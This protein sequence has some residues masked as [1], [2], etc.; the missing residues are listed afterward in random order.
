MGGVDA[1]PIP[2]HGR[3][4]SVTMTL[5]PLGAVFLQPIPEPAPEPA[6]GVGERAQ[7]LRR[8]PTP[9]AEAG[10]GASARSNRA[11]KKRRAVIKR[12]K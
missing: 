6:P 8:A 1:A 10:A 2:L 12:K 5:P 4:W 7:R 9:G 3:K 11:G